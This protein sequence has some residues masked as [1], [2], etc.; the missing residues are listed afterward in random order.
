[1]VHE[2][3]DS[4]VQQDTRY[5]RQIRLWGDHGQT[6]L[7]NAHVLVA[8]VNTTS[9]EAV[10]SLIL[11]GV[12]RITLLD[13]H[14]VDKEAI[15]SNFFLSKADLGRNC[16]EAVI[17]DISELNPAVK[18]EYD[19]RN[20]EEVIKTSGPEFFQSFTIVL[21]SKIESKTRRQLEELLFPLKIPL[22]LAESTGMFGRI[23]LFFKE[24]FIM[25]GKKDHT[26]PDLRLDCPFPELN[27]YLRSFDL[28]S[29]DDFNHKHVPMIVPLFA[30]LEEWRN[31]NGREMPNFKGKK[32][33]QTK[34]NRLRR[35]PDEENFDE[36]VAAVNTMVGGTKMPADIVNLFNHC[37]EFTEKSVTPD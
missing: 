2:M 4:P 5:D 7:E 31:E 23:R 11:P 36:A 33:I 27:D 12:G 19:D 16:A 13:H 25:E 6:A 20:I 37:K 26:V 22:V 18:M 32:E 17:S 14:V 1:M 8:G 3:C 10:K 34:I 15:S 24:H 28:S 9:C 29:M 35:A 21:C 30:A